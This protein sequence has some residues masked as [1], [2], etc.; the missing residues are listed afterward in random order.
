[1]ASTF[2]QQAFNG[3]T[4]QYTC[5]WCARGLK[6]KVSNSAKNPGRSFVSCSKDY[7]GC[8]LF[9][10]L[11]AMPD[12]KHRPNATGDNS[13]KR[14]RTDSPRTGGNNVIGP[15][16]DAPSAHEARLADLAAKIDQLAT[17]IGQLV[18]DVS[19]VSAY[20]KEVSDN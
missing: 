19:I 10:F 18:M 6:S 8:G 15:I 7:G 2:W 1:M 16:A 11:D 17:V 9:C 12:D 5:P 4:K 14:A 13:S 3:D 20:V